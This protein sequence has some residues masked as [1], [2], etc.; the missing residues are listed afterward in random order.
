MKITQNGSRITVTTVGDFDLHICPELKALLE[1]DIATEHISHICFDLQKTDF[2]DSSGLGLILWIYKQI[3]PEGGKVT[4]I[5]ASP[6][7][8]KIFEIAD[9]TRFLRGKATGRE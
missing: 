9:L 4:V 5:N 6:A 8:E 2:I 7:A 1:E 3:A